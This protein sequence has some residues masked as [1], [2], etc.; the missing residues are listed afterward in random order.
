MG[1][2]PATEESSSVSCRQGNHGFLLFFSK[3]LPSSRIE[4]LAAKD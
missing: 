1:P 2:I 4:I 3:I